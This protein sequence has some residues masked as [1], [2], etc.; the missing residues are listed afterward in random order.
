MSVISLSVIEKV[1]KAVIIAVA[2]ILAGRVSLNF[3][4]KNMDKLKVDRTLTKFL[5]GAAKLV[6]YFIAIMIVAGSLGF[7]M[8]SLVALASVVSAAFALAASGVLSNLFGGILLLLT[9]P[10]GVDD[11]I[12][13]SGQEGTVL[14]IGLVA[15]KIN[16]VDNKRITI[17]NSSI[18]NSTIVNYSTEGKRRVD[19]VFSVGYEND[20]ETVRQAIRKVAEAHGKVI[21]KQS[22]F[23]R[24]SAFNA[25]DISYTLRVWCKTADYWDVYFDMLEQIKAEFDKE[26]ISFAY[27]HMVMVSQ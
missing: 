16:T 24:T 22:I 11:Y 23:V 7:E 10:F 6:I 17:P 19:L 25:S 27:P 12:S 4:G 8:S 1:A 15:T 26:G 18:S 20:G 5:F 14:E 21:D 3:L 13:I 9:K 2:V